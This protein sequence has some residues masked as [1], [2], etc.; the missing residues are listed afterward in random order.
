MRFL[1]FF[2]AVV[3]P[4]SYFSQINNRQLGGWYSIKLENRL[5]NDWSINS[6]VHS[7]NWRVIDD[8]QQFVIGFG[9]RKRTSKRKIAFSMVNSF[10]L[11]KMP[12]PN[13]TTTP[14]LRIH[15]EVSIPSIILGRVYLSSIIR[16]EQRFIQSEPFRLRIRLNQIIRVP[17][18]SKRIRV[19]TLYLEFSNELFTNP[20][21]SS[22]NSHLNFFDLDRLYLGSSYKL[23]EKVI[24]ELGAMRQVTSTWSK[25]QI[26]LGARFI[27]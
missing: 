19:K 27:I 18:N 14:E 12:T 5:Q 8:L 16:M 15:Q 24:L 9:I 20:K 10:F 6:E 4:I 21:L 17:L 25:N 11:S 26:L 13:N 1:L 3:V 23:S 22:V 7:R 2:I